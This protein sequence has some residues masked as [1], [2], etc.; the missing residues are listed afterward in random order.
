MFRQTPASSQGKSSFVGSS[1]VPSIHLKMPKKNRNLADQSFLSS[2]KNAPNADD[3]TG[4]RS[5]QKGY[6][7]SKETTNPRVLASRGDSKINT[8]M[9]GRQSQLTSVRTGKS[10]RKSSSKNRSGTGTT[11][12]K[13]NVTY[14]KEKSSNHR[15]QLKEV[16]EYTDNSE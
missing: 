11:T 1:S 12:S 4:I 16:V 14:E 8:P 5:A 15:G 13:A 10:P 7:Q 3:D 6:K 2:I 9:P